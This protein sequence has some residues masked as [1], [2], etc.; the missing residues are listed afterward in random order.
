MGTGHRFVVHTQRRLTEAMAAAERKLGRPLAPAPGVLRGQVTIACSQPT[1][2]RLSRLQSVA[3]SCAPGLLRGQPLRGGPAF[4]GDNV[5]FYSA[6]G[7]GWSHGQ[8]TELVGGPAGSARVVEPKALPPGVRETGFVRRPA[9]LPG[10]GRDRSRF[11]RAEDVSAQ[12]LS[13]AFFCGHF[14]AHAQE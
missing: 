7:G 9:N 12:R 1:A 10:G 6:A 13:D 8:V 14:T 11:S 3:Y 2:A 4:V 5:Y